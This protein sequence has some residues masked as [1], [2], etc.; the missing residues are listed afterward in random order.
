MMEE[1]NDVAYQLAHAGNVPSRDHL[2]NMPIS[3]WV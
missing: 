1:M 3:D 2:A